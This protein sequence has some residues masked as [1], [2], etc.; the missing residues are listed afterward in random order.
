VLRKKNDLQNPHSIFTKNMIIKSLFCTK[1]VKCKMNANLTF[2]FRN[3]DIVIN[4]D[5]V[6]MGEGILKIEFI[7]TI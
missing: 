2:Y 5:A 3:D 4:L 7:Q 6:K 1:R